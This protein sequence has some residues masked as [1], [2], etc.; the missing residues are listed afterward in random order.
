M[1][2]SITTDDREKP[3]HLADEMIYWA[4]IIEALGE[5]SAGIADTEKNDLGI[6]DQSRECLGVVISHYARGIHDGLSAIYWSLHE[7]FS[8]RPTPMQGNL[9]VARPHSSCGCQAR[10]ADR[11][12]S[13]TA[14]Q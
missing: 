2:T 8:K 14:G 12:V 7:E 3:R 5:I 6:S 11:G 4:I 10:E 9:E 1:T 13:K